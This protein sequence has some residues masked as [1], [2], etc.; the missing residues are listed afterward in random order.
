MIMLLSIFDEWFVSVL[1]LLNFLCMLFGV[2]GIVVSLMFW[3]NDVIY[4]Y[5]W[6]LELV[7][8]YV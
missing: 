7:S 4:Y 8:V 6:L 2:I 3:E 5:V 1:G